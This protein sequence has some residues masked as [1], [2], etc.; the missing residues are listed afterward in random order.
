MVLVAAFH[1]PLVKLL[2]LIR[3]QHLADLDMHL[4]S[5]K[6]ILHCIVPGA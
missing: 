5:I 6:L 3:S 4:R 2:A 1:Q